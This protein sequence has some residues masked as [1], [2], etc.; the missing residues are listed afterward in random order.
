MTWEYLITADSS[1]PDLNR[2]GAEGWELVAVSTATYLR[3]KVMGQIDVA[4][5]TVV[6]WTYFKRP[7]QKT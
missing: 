7:T 4:S 1:A 2:F 3:S 6:R 5:P